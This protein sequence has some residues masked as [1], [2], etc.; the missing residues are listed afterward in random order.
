MIESWVVF[1]AIT[2]ICYSFLYFLMNVSSSRLDARL[3]PFVINFS[4]AIIT[5]TYL[6]YLLVAKEKIKVSSLGIFIAVIAGLCAGLGNIMNFKSFQAGGLVTLVL[7]IVSIGSA[8]IPFILGLVFLKESVSWI[9]ILAIG[10][11][12]VSIW[13]LLGS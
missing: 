6:T 9:Q 10:L 13:L 11:G 7:P 1:T 8:V 5:L 3:G 2:T 12:C 4:A